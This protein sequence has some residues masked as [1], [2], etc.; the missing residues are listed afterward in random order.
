MKVPS[1]Q[2]IVDLVKKGLTFEA[3]EKIM[4]LREAVMTLQEENVKLRERL[5][6]LEAQINRAKDLKFDGEVYWLMQAEDKKDGPFCQKC[7]DKDQKL[8]RLLPGQDPNYVKWICSVCNHVVYPPGK[9]PY[10]ALYDANKARRL[11]G[12]PGFGGF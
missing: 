9:G 7:Q 6:S 3:Q 8:V 2:E 4:T 5:L 11:E 12:S 1:Y 10:S